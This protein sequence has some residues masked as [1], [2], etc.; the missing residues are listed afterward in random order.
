MQDKEIKMSVN[1]SYVKVNSEKIHRIFSE[2]KRYSKS[3]SDETKKIQQT[4]NSK[5]IAKHC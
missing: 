1:L 2:A 3:C 4:S 5:K